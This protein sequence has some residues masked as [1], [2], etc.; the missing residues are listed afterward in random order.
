MARST[1]RQPALQ[2]NGTVVSTVQT[3]LPLDHSVR[4]NG[5]DDPRCL[6]VSASM[7]RRGTD[8]IEAPSVRITTIDQNISKRTARNKKEC[9]IELTTI[10][11]NHLPCQP[12]I[13]SEQNKENR[14]SF[15]PK[16]TELLRCWQCL[17]KHKP[18]YCEATCTSHHSNHTCSRTRYPSS[19]RKRH[20]S[21]AAPTTRHAIT[22]TRLQNNHSQ[23]HNRAAKRASAASS[24][25]QLAARS[26][27]GPS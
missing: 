9:R 4:Y 23:I 26:Y 12:K 16:L 21:G 7:K 27:S 22:A 13:Q 11:Q 3:K 10:K 19:R 25:T 5:G 20:V 14:K 24:I 2:R 18:T 15:L 17:I 1:E 6:V 8:T